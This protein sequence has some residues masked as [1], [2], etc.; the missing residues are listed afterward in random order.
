MEPLRTKIR[1]ILAGLRARWVAGRRAAKE[2]FARLSAGRRATDPTRVVVFSEEPLGAERLARLL[3]RH[4]AIHIEHTGLDVVAPAGSAAQLRWLRAA[5]SSR[6]RGHPSVVGI[7]TS[8]DG[9]LD[10]ERLS[11]VL[12]ELRPLI[13]HVTHEHV[14]RATLFREA[15]R[16]SWMWGWLWRRV[17]RSKGSRTTPPPLRGS[18]RPFRPWVFTTTLRDIEIR[19]VALRRF[20]ER[21]G[22]PTLHIDE[23]ELLVD[24]RSVL[25]DVLAHL[26][27]EVPETPC[28][29][30]GRA[31]HRYLGVYEDLGRLRAHLEDTPYEE[32][33]AQLGSTDRDAQAR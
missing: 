4:P 9:A 32:M 5:L 11:D 20:V 14:V 23:E 12:R 19:E 7:L 6:Q 22:L 30:L 16:R 1:R 13:V 17:Q 29:P 25:E 31:D 28:P 27:L 2:V 18:P 33:L 26:G 24:E 3:H 15:E 21:L 8:L 10:P